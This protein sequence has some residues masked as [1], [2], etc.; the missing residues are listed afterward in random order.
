MRPLR[1]FALCGPFSRSLVGRDADDY[2][3][4]SVTLELALGR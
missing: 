3:E 2:Y 4:R 1:S